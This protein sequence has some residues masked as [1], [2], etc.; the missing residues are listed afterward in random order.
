MS[1]VNVMESPPLT[2]TVS[3]PA[4]VAPSLH[5]RS[6]EARSV[7]HGFKSESSSMKTY[8]TCGGVDLVPVTGEL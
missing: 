2:L 5:R 1:K 8:G 6:F 7:S 4:P 3:V